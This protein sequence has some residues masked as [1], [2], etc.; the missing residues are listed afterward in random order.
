MWAL[1]PAVLLAAGAS[2]AR[3]ELPIV[4]D[5]AKP[6]VRLEALPPPPPPPPALARSGREA[7][8]LL[9]VGGI[10]GIADSLPPTVAQGQV[11]LLT[12]YYGQ[13][14]SPES[15]EIQGHASL[16]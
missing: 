1:A 8:F 2:A 12:S 5:A 4:D 11:V 6:G 3:T 16:T 9:N 7:P 13:V 14:K 15:R 10:E